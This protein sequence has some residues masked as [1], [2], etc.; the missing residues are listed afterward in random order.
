MAFVKRDMK[1]IQENQVSLGL[2][3]KSRIEKK[4]SHGLKLMCRELLMRGRNKQLE[5]NHQ[6]YCATH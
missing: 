3:L 5:G 6:L 4:Q 1:G 2:E